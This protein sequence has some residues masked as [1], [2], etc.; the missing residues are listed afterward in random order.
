MSDCLT[1]F[2]SHHLAGFRSTHCRRCACRECDYCG[3]SLHSPSPPHRPP[4]LPQTPSP[5]TLPPPLCPSPDQHRPPPPSRLQSR[6]SLPPVHQP[7]SLVLRAPLTAASPLHAPLLAA[8]EEDEHDDPLRTSP[9]FQ[10]N[11]QRE[12][13]GNSKDGSEG[14]TPLT[15][16]HA[17]RPMTS[18]AE[19]GAVTRVFAG[20]AAGCMLCIGIVLCWQGLRYRRRSGSH[21]RPRSGVASRSRHRRLTRA[22][23][24]HEVETLVD[25]VFL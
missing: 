1:D 20:G 19:A 24:S 22:L 18:T 8:Q 6:S 17:V 15:L 11:A 4:P 9:V 16:Q 12:S 25:H 14:G 10:D 21:P 7:S 5:P 3:G 23:D 2:D 13:G